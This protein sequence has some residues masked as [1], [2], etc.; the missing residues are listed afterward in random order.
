MNGS[1]N[2]QYLELFGKPTTRKEL[3]E[4]LSK[5]IVKL[6]QGF[7]PG[8]SKELHQEINDGIKLAKELHKILLK[9]WDKHINP[10]DLGVDNR[11]YY[12]DRKLNSRILIETLGKLEPGSKAEVLALPPATNTSQSYQANGVVRGAVSTSN[13]KEKTLIKK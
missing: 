5:L 6:R 1:Q 10:L 3:K 12:L 9:D 8:L 11:N 13:Q 2:C 4:G 7:R